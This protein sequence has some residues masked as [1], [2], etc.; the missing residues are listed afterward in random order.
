MILTHGD[1]FEILET[2]WSTQLGLE[3]DDDEQPALVSIDSEEALM[4]GAVQISG[5]FAGAVHLICGRSV[6]RAAAARMF[7]VSEAELTDDDLRDALGELTNMVGGNIKTLLPGSES[8]SLPTVIEGLNYGVARLD[9]DVVAET[10]GSY[11]G[12]PLR[13]VLLADHR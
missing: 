9:S 4:T 6:V 7:S 8:I 5:G 2:I 10:Q 13:A 11:E 12:R 1:L 3:L